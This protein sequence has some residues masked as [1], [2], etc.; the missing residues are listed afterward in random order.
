MYDISLIDETFDINMSSTYHLSIQIGRKSFTYCT[1]DSVTNKYNAI[2]HFYFGDNIPTEALIQ[3]IKEVIKG[4]ELL[5]KRFKT[6]NTVFITNKSILIPKPL[7]RQD[8]IDKYFKLNHVIEDYEEIIFNKFKNSDTYLAFTVYRDLKHFLFERM[9]EM[10]I[11][12]QAN[13]IVDINLMDYKNKLTEPKVFVNVSNDLLDVAVLESNR[14]LFYNSFSFNNDNDFA[15]YLMNVYDR[16]KL[17][18]ETIELVLSGEIS[19]SSKI[20]MLIKNY[21]KVLKFA[22]L[23]ANYSYSYKFKEVE[24]HRF[25]NIINLLR[26]V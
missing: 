26:C 13:I 7:F 17:N 24:A 9:P 16:L 3:T 2:K 22:K 6:I 15:Y 23:P 5:K 12:H 18:P 21:I 20:Y 11:F 25:T 10:R 14:L 19:K 1:L 4:E 8:N